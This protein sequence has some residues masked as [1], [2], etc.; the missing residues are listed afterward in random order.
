MEILPAVDMDL[1]AGDPLSA[2]PPVVKENAA[3]LASLASA[4][5]REI[6]QLQ[7]ILRRQEIE[8]ASHAAVQFAPSHTHAAADQ[9]YITLQR[10]IEAAGF[11]AAA[12]YMLDDDTQ[13]LNTRA[14]VGLPEDRLSGEPR[15]L[16]GSRADLEALVQDAVLMDDLR[17][18]M[19]PTWNAPEAAGAA[20]CTALLKGDLPLGTLWLFADEPRPLDQ[21][22][23]AI[24]QLASA[25]IS[26]ELGAAA[27]QRREHRSREASE[28]VGEIAAWQYSSL[29]ADN[30]LAPNWFVDGMVES[31]HQ[32]SIGWHHWDVLP[33]GSL[34]LAIAEALDD[35]ASGA[36]IAATARAAMMS[37]CGYRH[38]PKQ[39]LQRIGDTLWHTNAAEQLVSLLYARIDPQTGDGEVAVAGQISGLIAGRYGYRPLVQS[40]GRPLASGFEVDCYE[41]CF[42]LA[43]G[44][45][46]LAYGGG[47]KKDGIGQDLLG[48]CLRSATQSGE[49]ALALL[50]REIAGFPNRAERGLVSLTRQAGTQS[51]HPR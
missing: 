44:E 17:G 47:L 23:G 45:T 50:R 38:T 43:E 51:Q 13:Y 34:M 40:G 20:V 9:I 26:L 39:L 27:Q 3:Q 36:M 25:Q 14:V 49:N 8:L 19:G 5:A 16:R 6:E 28:A 4:M 41:S 33:D 31:P 29:P 11:D 21:S 7:S 37:H 46:L 18:P 48:C 12:I 35:R 32:W 1:M 30:L 42:Q 2:H 24:A 22:V 10:A 15:L